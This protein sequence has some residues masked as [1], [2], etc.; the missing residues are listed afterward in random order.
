[1]AFNYYAKAKFNQPDTP[2]TN[3]PPPIPAGSW[4]KKEEKDQNPSKPANIVFGFHPEVRD[5]N[6]RPCKYY[7]GSKAGG[8][9]GGAYQQA[10]VQRKQSNETVKTLTWR[11]SN[12]LYTKTV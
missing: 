6:R 7:T 1:M 10:T 12:V 2:N 4:K 3:N 5:V 8:G 11:S 9:G